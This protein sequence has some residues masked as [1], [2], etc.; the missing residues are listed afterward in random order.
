MTA[1]QPIPISAQQNFWYA[2][3]F[4]LQANASGSQVLI[5]ANDS[6]F[7]LYSLTAVTDQDATLTGNTQGQRP[8]NFSLAL[9]DLSSGRD[10]QSEAIRR[11]NI[12]GLTEFNVL[13]EGRPIRF[14]RKEQIQVTVNNLVA[15][16]INVQ[17]TLHGYK[18]FT[19]FPPALA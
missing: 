4:A 7:D 9:K 18:I 6:E 8:E 10:F 2:L 15:V 11:G 17:I 14:P 1:R 19:N 16:A 13:A 5:L 3:T 12:A